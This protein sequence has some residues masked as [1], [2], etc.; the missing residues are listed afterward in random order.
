MKIAL[1][2]DIHI[3]KHLGYDIFP[4]TAFTFLEYFF[5]YCRKRHIKK[6]FFAGDLFHTKTKV[7]TIEFVKTKEIFSR[8]YQDF[9]IYMIV[10]NH[11]MPLQNTTEGSI[12]FALNDYAEVI[13]DY[14]YFDLSEVRYHF[15]SY[16]KEPVLPEFKYSDGKNILIAH[17]DI[18]GFKM[19][20]YRLSLE[21]VD[22]KA[23]KKFDIIFSGHYHM[24][25]H[26]SNLVYIGSPFQ[27][28]FGERG[29]KKGFIIFDDESFTWELKEYKKAPKFKV[30]TSNEIAKANINNYF[31][32]IV[33]N[34]NINSREV[35]RE[36]LSR[37]ALSVDVTYDI[38]EYAKELEFI[39][40]LN[41]SNVKSLA[42]QYIENVSVPT[43]INKKKLLTIFD[44]IN[45]LYLS[46][47][48]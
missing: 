13:K 32:R 48:G 20:D 11:D 28:N 27:I 12:L 33:A 6:I 45:D 43:E 15:M 21:G 4:K 29:Q 7:D 46:I 8:N 47:R 1:F 23:F 17:Q 5:D 18:V 39:E 19:N 42:K 25:Q 10:G 37:G 31:V 36:L 38:E 22:L 14:S 2:S 35:T 9:D 30:I 34:S 26:K 16:R 41:K 44:K 40:E 3:Y 24:H